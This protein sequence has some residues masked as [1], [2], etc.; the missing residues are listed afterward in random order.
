MKI[1]LLRGPL[2]APLG[3]LNNEPTP[4]LGLACLSAALRQAGHTVSAVDATGRAINRVEPIP[5]TDLQ[6]NGLPASE[7]VNALDP[8]CE[9]LG[10]STMFSHE[11]IYQRTL[12]GLLR[13]RF[14]ETPILLGGEHAS[15]L[16][17]YILGDCPAVD[18]IC[19][20]E[21]EA[22]FL[23]CMEAIAHSQPLHAVPG[24]VARGGQRGPK[25]G[26]IRDLN[27]LPWP[28]WDTL[29]IQ[30]YLE[31]NISFGPSMGRN[32]PVLATRGC[33]YECTFC[34]NPIMWGRRYTMRNPED[35]VAEIVHYID[36]YQITG[37]QF[38]D[39]TAI[40]KREW[41]L[42]FC[43]C[44]QASGADVA[45]SLPS[46]TRCEALDGEVLRA[47]ADTRC[48]YLVFAPESGSAEIRQSI[49]KRLDMPRMDNA[50]RGA[51]AQGIPVRCN[52]VLGFPQ[53][54]RRDIHQTLWQQVRYA[55]MG[56][57]EAPLYPFQPY[58]GSACFDELVEAQ[59]IRLD[60]TYFLTLATLSTGRLGP[61][62]ESYCRHVGR[63]QL[64]L[65]RM[66]GM[67][68]FYGLS[69]L[70]RPG[71]ILRT[72]RQVFWG[73]QTT[74]VLEQRLKDRVRHWRSSTAPGD[75]HG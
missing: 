44:L 71:R 35:V 64:Y 65:Y 33:P 5:G 59:R 70:R 4:P 1:G 13:E 34:S 53:E 57:D 72:L 3:S 60:D 9:V 36:S 55:W 2:V 41:I 24:V 75:S 68:L 21:G 25:R 46:G 11:W 42:E 7:A 63:L 27:A 32:M 62:K 66:F 22:C 48:R 18:A 16:P 69:Y 10:I 8:D 15:A 20:G 23:E 19:L 40:L 56:V 61:A 47:M 39:L 74:T 51:L 17:D 49:K 37:V 26:R 28:D 43:R 29:P 73:S 30:P 45:W 58:P 38:Y 14:P 12:L 31:Q 52:L 54:T 50:I 67:A 6:Y